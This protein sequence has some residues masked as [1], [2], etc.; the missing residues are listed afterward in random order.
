[1]DKLRLLNSFAWFGAILIFVAY[2]L[3]ATGYLDGDSLVYHFMV[4]IGSVGIILNSVKKKDF[5]PA[6]L[7]IAFVVAA[8]YAIVR[9]IT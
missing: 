4:L 8:I 7:N 6:V 3:L 1:M 9:I 2:L 5:Q